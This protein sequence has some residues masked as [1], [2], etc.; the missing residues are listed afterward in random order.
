MTC[1]RN[2]DFLVKIEYLVGYIELLIAQVLRKVRITEYVHMPASRCP[3]GPDDYQ[4]K[5]TVN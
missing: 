2:A 1:G 4:G 3:C 5:E